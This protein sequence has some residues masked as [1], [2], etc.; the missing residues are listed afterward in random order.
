MH[1]PTLMKG[2]PSPRMR[3]FASHDVLTFRRFAVSLGVRRTKLGPGLWAAGA[4]MD[5]GFEVMGVT[6]VAGTGVT[7]DRPRD[8]YLCEFLTFP[9]S[10]WAISEQAVHGLPRVWFGRYL[11]DKSIKRLSVGRTERALL[12]PPVDDS[13]TRNILRPHARPI[14]YL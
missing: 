7:F 5:A 8:R 10:G 14:A 13:L 4:A 2:G 12:V 6:P 9:N 11:L 1:L 3:A